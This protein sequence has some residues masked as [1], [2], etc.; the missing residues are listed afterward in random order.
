MQ[1]ILFRRPEGEYAIDP[2]IDPSVVNP[3]T[4]MTSNTYEN[5]IYLCFVNRS[6]GI[7]S[8]I[9][10]LDRLLVCLA[11]NNSPSNGSYTVIGNS[12][13]ISVHAIPFPNGEILFYGRP[14]EPYGGGD[15]AGP[16]IHYL[17]VSQ[18]ASAIALFERN[19]VM[20]TSV[21]LYAS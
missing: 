21:L 19:E 5:S 8:S 14:G 13:M 3:I 10:E 17:T 11:G 1:A 7:N 4:G 16:N 2:K 15:P 18:P 9:H 20:T 6:F 12:G